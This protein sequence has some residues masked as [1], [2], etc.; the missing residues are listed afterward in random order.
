MTIEWRNFSATGT[1][2]SNNNN[3]IITNEISNSW[4]PIFGVDSHYTL[5]NLDTTDK[6]TEEETE[7]A[8]G[9]KRGRYVRRRA[10]VVGINVY[11]NP[12]NNL[13]GCVPDAMDVAETLKGLGFPPTRIKLLLNEQA[14]TEGILK[15]L[16]WLVKDAAENDVLIFYFSGHGSQIADLNNDEEDRVDEILVPH[17]INFR[18]GKYITDD[19]LFEKFT[20]KVPKSVRTDVVLD[21]CF[22]GSATRSI[23]RF[24]LSNGIKQRYLPPPVDHQFRLN[25]M[26]PAL[27]NRNMLGDKT[28]NGP[29]EQI[30]QNNVLLSACQPDQL[31]YEAVFGSNN[32]I[33]GA[34]TF[35]LCNILRAHN[36][37]ISRMNLY[38][39]LRA[40]VANDGFPQIPNL[41]VPSIEMLEIFPFRKLSEIDRYSEIKK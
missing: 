3:N 9:K 11:E 32:E 33:R 12:N 1:T 36:G 14:T 37:D 7:E 5:A 39:E 19:M 22:S 2:T 35:Y 15:G 23:G 21:C 25:S 20:T 24:S 31:A 16:D 41:E 27:T 30:G 10:L 6:E 17:D 28:V 18:D 4:T 34:H 26:I 8:K 29:E 38:S 13:N 40:A